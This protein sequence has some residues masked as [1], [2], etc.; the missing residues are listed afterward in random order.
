MRVAP[1][2]ELE[3]PV[4]GEDESTSDV[5]A[6]GEDAAETGDE[7]DED[8]EETGEEQEGVPGWAMG[9]VEKASQKGILN[10]N[11][12]HS[13]VQAE[14]AQV[15]V[16]VAKTMGLEPVDSEELP[17]TDSNLLSTEDAGYLMA[18]YI[19]WIYYV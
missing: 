5:E 10:M 18:L 8:Q 1:D 11:R 17:F 15:A 16:W 4:E 13:H 12:F 2:E 19:E 14:R 3:E 6:Q 7:N 9:A